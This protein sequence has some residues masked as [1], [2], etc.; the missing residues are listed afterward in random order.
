MSRRAFESSTLLT[1]TARDSLQIS[2]WRMPFAHEYMHA[3]GMF[4]HRGYPGR[5][6]LATPPQPCRSE[7][8]AGASAIELPESSEISFLDARWDEAE[9]PLSSKELR[10][11]APRGQHS[12]F[13]K[14]DVPPEQLFA[15]QCRQ[16][17]GS[18]RISI[19]VTDRVSHSIAKDCG[20]T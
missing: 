4:T 16:G 11:A 12:G 9:A 3:A 17:G 8:R 1:M 10:I 18:C 6:S 20:T 15:A 5:R 14:N 2:W 19:R 7:R 13:A